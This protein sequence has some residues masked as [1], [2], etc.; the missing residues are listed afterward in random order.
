[1]DDRLRSRPVGE[2]NTSCCKP[3]SDQATRDSDTTGCTQGER[4]KA[5]KCCGDDT[6]GCCDGLAA[7]EKSNISRRKL[8][9]TMEELNRSSCHNEAT[10]EDNLACSDTC[11]D[12]PDTDL[13]DATSACSSHLQS[14]FD[15]FESLIRL[16]QCLCRKMI[17]EFS[18]CCCCGQGT[19]QRLESAPG[20]LSEFKVS[21]ED[22]C[23]DSIV[24][25]KVNATR[26]D[27]SY[28]KGRAAGPPDVACKDTQGAMDIGVHTDDFIKTAPVAAGL[29]EPDLERTIEKT[30][31]DLSVSG[32]TCTGCSRK[33]LNVLC[34]IPGISNPH[35]TF[36]SGTAAFDFDPT[37]GDPIKVLPIIEKRTGFKLS[38]ISTSFLELDVLLSA[39]NAEVYEREERKGLVSFDKVSLP[40]PRL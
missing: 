32:M 40:R 30:H 16:G 28:V 37:Q 11:C 12:A 20:S 2:A 29:I 18:F 15:R 23:C 10:I 26:R 9:N 1:V 4:S 14:A 38:R 25:A 3:Q 21:C 6:I 13:A 36:V 27:N 39:A 8:L 34:D 17:R 5:G 24:P 7:T 22:C 19:A 31:V 35:V 33:M